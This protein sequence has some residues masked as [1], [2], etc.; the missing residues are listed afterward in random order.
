MRLEG[1]SGRTFLTESHELVIDRDSLV[2]IPRQAPMKS[3]KIPET[4]L[5]RYDDSRQF[6]FSISKEISI[7]K[8]NSCATIDAALVKF[9]LIIRPTQVGD[10]FVPFGMTG[11]KPCQ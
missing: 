3:L 1:E 7:S 11:H 5:Y 6:I 10:K 4:G 2:L 9:P 8:S